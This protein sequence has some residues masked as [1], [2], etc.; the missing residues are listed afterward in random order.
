MGRSRAGRVALGCLCCLFAAAATYGPGGVSG[1]GEVSMPEVVEAEVGQTALIPC[2]FSL[3]ENGSYA[4]IHWYSLDKAQR[5]RI[6]SLL[7]SKEQSEDPKLKDRLSITANFSL[8]I[9]KVVLQDATVYICQVG[10]GILGVAE[11]RTRLR[12]SKAPEPP[13]IQ[14]TDRGIMASDSE[15]YEIAKCISR[16]G[17]P[18][19]TVTWYKDEEPLTENGKDIEILPRHIMES[20][21]LYT[22]ESTLLA[23]VTKDDRHAIFHCQVDYSLMGMNKTAVSRNFT[24]NIHYPSEEISFEISPPSPVVKEGDSVT[25]HCKADGNPPRS[26]L[27]SRSRMG[28]RSCPWMPAEGKWSSG[29]SAG[30]RAASTCAKPSTCNPSRSSTSRSISLCTIWTCPQSGASRWTRKTSSVGTHEKGT[31]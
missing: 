17:Y 6:I 18:A 14:K 28:R 8:E 4:Y 22:V 5:K 2:R 9:R 26:T 27:W 3:P 7:K 13:V 1:E 25:L 20:S 15:K 24:I 11:N 31:P 16:N 12:V 19:S 10:L 21:G 23:Q 29:T 30:I